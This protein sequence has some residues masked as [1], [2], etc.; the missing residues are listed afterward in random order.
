ME[1]L[2]YEELIL[3]RIKHTKTECVLESGTSSE[4]VRYGAA[5]KVYLL[6]RI[7]MDSDRPRGS[8]EAMER[9]LI[10]TSDR[11]QL[12]IRRQPAGGTQVRPRKK[13]KEMCRMSG[14]RK[15]YRSA[16]WFGRRI[17][18]VYPPQLDEE[19]RPAR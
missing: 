18:T 5:S 12:S 1:E 9:L 11:L 14:D 17:R 7:S 3:C 16:A 19:S 2:D 6:G 8:R 10:R 13:R 4:S 15:V